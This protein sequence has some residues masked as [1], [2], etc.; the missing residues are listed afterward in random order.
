[1]PY[2]GVGSD[3]FGSLVSMSTLRSRARTIL[4]IAPVVQQRP[5][6]ASGGTNL[7]V[8][9][10]E[11]T[12]IQARRLA[13]DGSIIDDAALRIAEQGTLKALVFNGSD[14]LAM[15]E[16]PSHQLTIT[17][18]PRDGALRTDGGGTLPRADFRGAASDGVVTLVLLGTD[19]QLQVTRILGDGS[20]ADTLS[21]PVGGVGQADVAARDGEFL[22]VWE[23]Y[24]APEVFAT[25]SGLERRI[26]GARL[27]SSLAL[28]GT[29]FRISTQ[30]SE[31]YAPMAAW[32]GREWLVLWRSGGAA[33]ET[34]GRRVSSDGIP[35]GDGEGTVIVRNVLPSVTWDGSRYVLAW[36]GLDAPTTV[37]VGFLD[38]L[39]MPFTSQSTLERQPSD[40]SPMLLTPI[41]PGLVAAAYARVV[42]DPNF[43]EATR[44]FVNLL[45][46]PPPKRRGR[47]VR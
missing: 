31:Q 9:W 10:E 43:R 25:P 44:V 39:G 7:L 24:V 15:W 41:R 32:N 19:T 38:D 23:G 20:P 33:S 13:T 27:S 40:F 6:V 46:G 34:R 37:H 28:L 18:I 4:S 8:A 42:A 1:M 29:P 3:V 17:R 35:Q 47:A 30:Q 11:G 5:L 22:V 16:T 36:W 45:P 21:L 14:Y 2:S 26:L 12:A